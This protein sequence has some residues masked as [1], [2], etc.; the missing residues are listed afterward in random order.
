VPGP[1]HFFGQRGQ[2]QLHRDHVVAPP[3]QDGNHPAPAGPINPCP[4]H[5]QHVGFR[6]PLLV[7]A[8]A[9][10]AAG[11]RPEVCTAARPANAAVPF[12]TARRVGVPVGSLLEALG[13][14]AAESTH[15]T[16]NRPKQAVNQALH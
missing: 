2:R 8:G 11:A 5:Q 10:S 3:L 13:S 6:R 12:N 16:L 14:Q 7:P 9:A 1:G 4:V 15:A